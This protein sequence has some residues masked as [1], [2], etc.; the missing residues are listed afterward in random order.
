M[1]HQVMTVDTNE[2][3]RAMRRWATGVS[4]VSTHLEGVDHGMTVN[5]LTSISLDPPLV[6]V[7]LEQGT[8]THGM[9]KQSGFFGVS[10]LSQKHQE[11]SDRFAG[12][13]TEYDDRYL[14]LETTTMITDAPLLV[15]SLSNLDC[16]VVST[17]EAGTHTIFIGK[18]LAAQIN[19]VADPLIYYNRGYREL[20]DVKGPSKP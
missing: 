11:I 1:Y 13:E 16:R 17:Y 5:S 10:I 18:V 20:V 12:R 7:S 9:V 8:R 4:I 19:G 6:L 14:G 3:R 15:D 2:L